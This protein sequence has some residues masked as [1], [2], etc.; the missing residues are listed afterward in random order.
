MKKSIKIIV[1]LAFVLF[2]NNAIAQFSIG[3]EI[4]SEGRNLKGNNDVSIVL[5]SQG[6][7][8]IVEV[9][10]DDIGISLSSKSGLNLQYEY[11]GN[12]RFYAICD[13]IVFVPKNENKFNEII[14]ELNSNWIKSKNGKWTF[15]NKEKKIKSTAEIQIKG[16]IKSIVINGISYG[17]RNNRNR[18]AN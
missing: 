13:S 8:V 15:D 6:F 2:I 10:L 3:K 12:G 7:P 5:N 1:L 4:E 18:R 17:K 16:G 9:D 14:N 11:D